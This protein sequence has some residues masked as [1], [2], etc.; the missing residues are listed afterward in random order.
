VTLPKKRSTPWGK[1][2]RSAQGEVKVPGSLHEHNYGESVSYEYG[3]AG[4]YFANPLTPKQLVNCSEVVESTFSESGTLRP[5]KLTPD[6][7]TLWR[8]VQHHV[9]SQLSPAQRE[10]LGLWLRHPK[11]SELA[12]ELERLR[13]KGTLLS[14][15]ERVKKLTLEVKAQEL[16]T[17]LTKVLRSS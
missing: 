11:H 6:Q 17:S 9:G 3:T 8:Q 1:P 2:L 13:S 5:R 16:L 4:A 7:K 12:A 15:S 10:Q 14:S